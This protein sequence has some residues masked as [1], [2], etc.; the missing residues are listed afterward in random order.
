MVIYAA[1]ASEAYAP[2]G[3]KQ[4]EVVGKDEKQGFTA[5]VGIQ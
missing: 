1:G 2:K 5:V 3:S 4:V